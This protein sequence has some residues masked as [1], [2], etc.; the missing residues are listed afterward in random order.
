MQMGQTKITAIVLAAGQG[1]RMNSRV[2]KQYLLLEDRPVLYYS[3]KAFED[4]DVERIILVT[5]EGEADL[6][7]E[8]I[9]DKYQFQKVTQIVIGGKERY[10]SVYSALCAAGETD[11]VLIHDGARPFLTQQIISDVINSVK[12]EKA[13]IVGVPV[14]DTVKIVNNK[15]IVESTPLRENVWMI[16]TPQA[17]EFKLIKK[18]YDMIMKEELIQVTDDAMVLEHTIGTPV[19]LVF[20]SYQNI[21]ITTMEDLKIAEA[22]LKEYLE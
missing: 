21:K 18:A 10:H 15:G 2:A 17:F 5:G 12:V 1:K 6:C 4:S 14:K 9:I 13:S 7:R 22:F 8:S 11:Y 16:Q 19:K 3:L 20:G